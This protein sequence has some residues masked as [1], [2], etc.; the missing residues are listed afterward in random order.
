MLVSVFC[1]LV[2][3]ERINCKTIQF[4]QSAL[5]FCSVQRCRWQQNSRKASQRQH[6]RNKKTIYSTGLMALLCHLSSLSFFCIS[7]CSLLFIFFNVC[8]YV[9]LKK[10]IAFFYS[11]VVVT[12]QKR[13]APLHDPNAITVLFW[14]VEAAL[15]L[16]LIL[17]TNVFVSQKLSVQIN[18]RRA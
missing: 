7:L 17:H 5:Y 13:N 12:E 4:I 15:L 10:H 8:V 1:C 14:L 16:L 6:S 3:R 2:E 9:C 11:A 18:C